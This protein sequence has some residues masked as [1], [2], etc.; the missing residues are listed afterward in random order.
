MSDTRL[1]LFYIEI[2]L[3]VLIAV[4]IAVFVICIVK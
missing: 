3:F 2:F 1:I 4:L